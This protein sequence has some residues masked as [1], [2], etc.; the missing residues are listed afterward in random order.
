M[1]NSQSSWVARMGRN[2]DDYPG[3]QPKR[4]WGQHLS[5]ALYLKMRVWEEG[6]ESSIQIHFVPNRLCIQKL[7][8]K[9]RHFSTIRLF[10]KILAFFQR[11]RSASLCEFLS[12]L[13]MRVWEEGGESSIQ[14]ARISCFQNC[15][16]LLCASLPYLLSLALS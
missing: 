8:H 10:N 2:F 4:S 7:Q 5:T 6:G 3:F 12:Y 1:K 11:I 15:L 14:L 9:M 13:K 16:K